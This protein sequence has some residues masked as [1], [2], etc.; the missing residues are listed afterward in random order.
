M[1]NGLFYREYPYQFSSRA[2]FCATPIHSYSALP[3]DE[4]LRTFVSLGLKPPMY[5]ILQG[6][7]LLLH[8]GLTNSATK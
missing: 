1:N 3:Q 4:N 2:L 8:H 7:N 5:H 6:Q